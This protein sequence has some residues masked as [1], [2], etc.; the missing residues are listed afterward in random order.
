M[1]RPPIPIGAHGAIKVTDLTARDAN[2]KAVGPVRFEAR[3]RWRDKDGSFRRP[4][5]SANTE[6]KARL[7][8]DKRCTE[9]AEE[10]FSGKLTSTT[11]VRTVAES[12]LADLQREADLG[13]FSHGSVR[14]YR[15]T[16][17]N[18]V[19]PRVGELRIGSELTGTACDALVKRVH[20]KV[21]YATAKTTR[22]VLRGICAYALR[23]DLLTFNPAAS[24]GRL[25][26][27][28]REEPRALTPAERRQL[29][30]NLG[31]VAK[32]HQ[33][34]KLGRSLGPRAKVWADL[35]ELVEA[36]LSTGVRLGELLAVT[37]PNFFRDKDGAPKVRIE[38]H[39]VR[40]RGQLVRKRYRK[41]SKHVLVLQVPEWSAPMWQRRKLTAGFGTLFASVGGGLVHPDNMG[42]RIREAFTE[43]GFA[44]LTSHGFRDTVASV[45]DEAKLPTRHIADQLGHATEATVRK[46][47]IAPRTANPESVAALES[48]L[49]EEE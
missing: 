18:Q 44:W 7:A 36:M 14:T 16:L 43:A 34:D 5:A 12:W 29:I 22:A 45:L 25:V 39:V 3:T 19:L 38:A 32:A 48:M 30:A 26:E 17:D 1:A 41:G 15:S 35:P 49:H 4:R 23:H 20:D 47:Y 13:T 8:V 46:H 27:G 6:N 9:L 2:G 31:K 42:H 33:A 10:I 24:I 28:D 40:E 21:G 11:R 37:G